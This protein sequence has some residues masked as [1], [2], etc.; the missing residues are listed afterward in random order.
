MTA[1]I[2]VDELEFYGEPRLDL[3]AEVALV[4]PEPGHD[5]IRLEGPPL[6]FHSTQRLQISEGAD[7]VALTTWPAELAR[8]ANYLYGEGLGLPLVAA[9]LQCKGW[10]VKA[11]PHIAYWTAPP[12]RRLYLNPPIEP[13]DYVA[14]WEDG[15][16]LGLVGSHSPEDVETGLRPACSAPPESNHAPADRQNPAST[17]RGSETELSS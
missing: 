2:G 17:W 10:T 11:T 1:H 6:S 12:S 3:L 16:A 13:A 7:G 4:K 9:A 5:W 15:E 8:Q 14:I